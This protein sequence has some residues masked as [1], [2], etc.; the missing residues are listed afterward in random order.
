LLN[1]DAYPGIDLLTDLAQ[2]LIK[3]RIGNHVLLSDI[4]QAY[5]QIKLKKDEDQ[6]MFSFLVM[7]KGRLVPYRYTSIVFG[8]VASPFIFNCILKLHCKQVSA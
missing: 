5:L 3:F 6:N 7:E 1:E 2:L 4:K 8:F